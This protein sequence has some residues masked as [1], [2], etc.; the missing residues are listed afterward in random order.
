ML[1]ANRNIKQVNVVK[2]PVVVKLSKAASEALAL[3][4]S[5]RV[6]GKTKIVATSKQYVT[7]VKKF[8]AHLK[9]PDLKGPISLATILVPKEFFTDEQMAD[10]VLELGK[11]LLHFLVSHLIPVLSFRNQLF[12]DV[13]SKEVSDGRA[14]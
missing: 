6:K 9:L 13:G 11:I 7:Y 5:E 2:K 1:R 3:S 12:V 14:E 8:R 10:F 4:L